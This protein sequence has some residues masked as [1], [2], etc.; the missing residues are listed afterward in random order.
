MEASPRERSREVYVRRVIVGISGSAG[1]LQA[2]RYATEMARLH[3][4][5]L[6]PVLAWTPPG[7]EIADQR[8]PSPY[9]RA[10]WKQAA[11]DRLWDAVKLAIGG[12]PDDVEFC[13]EIVKGEA[14]RVLSEVAS[15]QGDVLVI[16]AGRHGS[17]RRLLACKVSRYCLGHACCPIVAIPPSR[18][19]TEANGLHGWL[20]RHRLHPEKA[21]MHSADA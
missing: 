18:L 16:G 6:M 17:M 3:D 2:L 20:F 8:V 10:V 15:E 4:A 19:A 13:P 9:L 7:G 21:D 14:G 5:K 11:W 12:P 1:S